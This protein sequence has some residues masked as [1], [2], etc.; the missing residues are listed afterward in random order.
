MVHQGGGGARKLMKKTT[1][2]AQYPPSQDE[3]PQAIRKELAGITKCNNG[4]REESHET[5]RPGSCAEE[6]EDDR[7]SAA[8][9]SR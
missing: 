2:G 8:S 3:M 6:L 5:D 4:K 1:E 7:G 9:T